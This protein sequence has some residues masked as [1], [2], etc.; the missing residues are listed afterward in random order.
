MMFTAR[1]A[2]TMALF[3]ALGTALP[4][5]WQP[6]DN[7]TSGR[8]QLQAA[9]ACSSMMQEMQPISQACCGANFEYCQGPVPS[10]CEAACQPVFESFYS[11]CQAMIST[12]VNHAEFVAFQQICHPASN[13]ASDI[14]F[15]DDFESGM[16]KWRGQ[17]NGA[18]P[19]TATIGS[20]GGSNVLQ[21]NDCI[22]GGDAYSV[23]AFECSAATPC[24]VSYRMKGRGWQGF[25]SGFPENHIWTATPTDWRGGR[26]GTSQHV[27]TQHDIGSWH[28]VEY[29]F[30]S[31]VANYQEGDYT[32][33]IANTHFMF[34]GFDFD[35]SATAI[36]DIVIRRYTGS[37]EQAAAINAAVQPDNVLFADDFESGSGGWHGQGDH[38]R[39]ESALVSEDPGGEKGMVLTMSGCASGGDAFSTQTFECS[40]ANKC[41][42]SY[43]MKGRAWQGF[44]SGYPD[45]HIW[46][47]TPTEYTGQHVQTVHD[48]GNWHHIDYIFPV[49]TDSF[50]HGDATAPITNVHFMVEA[51]DADCGATYFVSTLAITPAS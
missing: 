45:N 30:P 39:P 15:Q 3:A 33:P 21:V 14:L 5:A 9:G 42:V 18:A 35:C 29:V 26:G 41:R 12:D 23:D 40:V 24:L 36:D 34:E 50:V 32:V 4:Q 17:T 46:T 38:P 10:R 51:N 8:R 49:D 19:E 48:T 47:A 6:A 28:D 1:L 27:Q 11:R 13:D 37:A 20:D 16:S 7:S 22:G 43:Y 25:S 44:S 2:T 31:G